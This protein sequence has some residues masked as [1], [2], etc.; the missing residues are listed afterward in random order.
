MVGYYCIIPLNEK[1]TDLVEAEK[2]DG[3]SIAPE[4]MIPH[5]KGRIRKT[6]SSIYIGGVVAKNRIRIRQFVLGSLIAHLNQEFDNGVSIV[7][8]R[9]VTDDGMRLIKKYDFKPV[10]KF[11]SQYEMNHIYKYDASYDS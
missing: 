2:L 1:G 4:H 10:N 3:T 8:S 9:P 5:R 6:P 11:V 7:F